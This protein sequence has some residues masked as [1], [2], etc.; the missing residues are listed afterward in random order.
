MS[1]RDGRG[2]LRILTV[3]AAVALAI[4]LSA[5]AV[6]AETTD[7]P[8]ATTTND[9]AAA[10]VSP[11][12]TVP[13]NHDPA[14]IRQLYNI[15][16]SR[17]I[18]DKVMLAMFEAGWVE[19]HMHNLNCGD[20]DSLGVFQQR[21]S[22]G[23]CN[24]A[25]LCMDVNH[26]TNKFLDQAIPNDRNNP[27]YTAGQLAQSV[28]RSGHPERYDQAEAKARALLA[29]AG[30]SPAPS[31]SW[32]TLKSGSS[33]VDVVAAQYLLTAN[34]H[35]TTA[36]GSFG[37]ATDSSVRAFQSAKGLAVDG[38]IGPNTWSALL[39]KVRQ[40][41]SGNAVKALQEQLNANGANLEVDGSFGPATNTAV[42]SF[43]S[44]K[45]IAVDG[46]VGPETWLN[47]IGS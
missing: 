8:E 3:I 6:M 36:D 44:S 13:P 31:P 27:G 17:G 15:G 16:V 35:S 41:D 33:G 24:P 14:I 39:V 43:Q 19:S 2:R 38:V 28:Q 18:N 47:L 26:A 22:M 37:P 42:R 5:P 23:W 9:T 46:V 29:E 20:R 21:P 1:F 40:G 45:K 12:C 11:M 32:P 30:G 34:G 10:E 25:S 7:V 4:G